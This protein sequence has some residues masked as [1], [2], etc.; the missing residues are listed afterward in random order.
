[1]QILAVNCKTFFFQYSPLFHQKIFQECQHDLRKASMSTQVTEL[2]LEEE[3]EVIE[4][5]FD[6]M[7]TLK[8]CMYSNFVLE[9]NSCDL[10]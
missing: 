2:S 7:S 6:E 5:D 8:V 1:M 9:K 4:D 3:E 10:L